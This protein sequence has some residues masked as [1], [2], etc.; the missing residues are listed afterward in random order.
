MLKKWICFLWAL[1]MVL[2]GAGKGKAEEKVGS[3]RIMP[4]WCGTAVSGG[5]VSLSRV[6]M[7]SADGY[8]LT[9]GLANWSMEE[10]DLHS[11]EWVNWF[12]GRGIQKDAF[13]KPLTEEGAVFDNLQSGV[14]LV[15]QVEADRQFLP[16]HPFFLVIPEGENWDVYRRPKVVRNSE[17]PKTGDRPAPIIAAMA[18]GLS[19]A[20]LM[21][22]VDEH[23]K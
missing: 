19:I 17:S 2:N 13:Q 22:I 11:A 23:K 4:Q 10:S 16:F 21:V 9:D 1:A 12:A 7:K 5:S 20:V 3:I 15:E 18:L 8:Y 14:Y 6:G